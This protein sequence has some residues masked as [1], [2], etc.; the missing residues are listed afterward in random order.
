M[1]KSSKFLAVIIGFLI[2]SGCNKS[3][4]LPPSEAKK[5]AKEAYIY[6]FPLVMNYK[7]LYANSINQNSGDYKGA[8]NQKSCEARLFTPE[9]QAIVTPNSDTPYCM[10]WSNLQTEPVVFSVPDVASNRY[11]SFQLIDLYTHNFFY[12]GS[13]TTGSKAGNYLIASENWKGDIPK[14][15]T[16]VVRCETD[17]FFTIIRTQLFD[18][19]DL[20]N[21]TILQEAYQ[22][23][24]LSQYLGKPAEK[25]DLLNKFPEWVEGSQFTEDSFQYLDAVLQF[26]KPVPTE[27]SL[28][29]SFAKLGIGTSRGFN[30]SRFD[31]E[32]QKAIREGIKE[33]FEEMEALI[34]SQSSDP[35]GSTKIFGTREFLS[36]SAKENYGFDN[37]YL[38]RAV[39]AYLGIYGN[40]A[41]EATYPMYLIDDQG[42][43]LDA[44][45]N[46]YTLTFEP[47]QIPPVKA[48]WSLTMYDGKT[49]LLVNN[50]LNKY[51][52]SSTN[53]DTFVKNENGSITLYI[54]SQSPGKNLEANWL[55]APEGTF[56]CVMRLY[57]PK[58]E[59]LKGEWIHPKM[60]INK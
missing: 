40:S 57:G 34:K 52:I 1:K 59:V 33:G 8:F 48:F 12:I 11:Y 20:A 43:P 50:P 39:G 54:Q 15:I 2:L 47:S 24:T 4:K 46:K 51:V 7:T 36:K 35:L 38:I 26:V 18:P 56:Y 5:I 42:Q 14:G 28:F 37:F 41:T 21:V 32:T 22:V 60:A 29:K 23:Q 19:A 25:K 55:P 31:E 10:F 45:K 9:D 30:I 27:D 58:Q 44:S 17:L 3:D 13:L 53:A 6:G 16:Q 49:Q